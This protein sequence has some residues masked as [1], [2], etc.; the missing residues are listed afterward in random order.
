MNEKIP[1]LKIER[2]TNGADAGL[3]LLTQNVGIGEEATVSIH[4]VHI[5]YLA[6]QCGLIKTPDPQASRTIETLTRRLCKIRDEISFLSTYMSK[7]QETYHDDFGYEINQANHIFDLVDEFCE[8]L[9]GAY[10]V[11]T[12]ANCYIET[13]G[14]KPADKPK[15]SASEN[16]G[17][18]PENAGA[19]QA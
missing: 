12:W 1:D 4:P 2:A 19:I 3:I 9:P 6:E 11:P 17:K 7:H 18:H 13:E 5:R 16:A 8:G 10:P 14:A 15:K